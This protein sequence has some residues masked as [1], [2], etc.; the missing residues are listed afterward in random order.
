MMQSEV[1]GVILAG[2]LS[3]RMGCD[4]NLLK[5]SGKTLLENAVTTISSVCEEVFVSVRSSS[6]CL[7]NLHLNDS[8][9]KV[10]VDSTPRIGPMGGII[11]ALTQ[12]QK[13]IMVLACDMPFMTKF[14]LES[15]LSARNGRCQG[16]HMTTF[17]HPDTGFIESL[18]AI[19][20]LEALPILQKCHDE[21]IYKLSKAIPKAQR[22]HIPVCGSSNLCFF[23]TNT[24][25]DITYARNIYVEN[26][27]YA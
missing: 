11:S 27:N 17:L 9:H 5:V 3:S 25:K 21:S 22:C 18:V 26:V 19:Y 24:M 2:G 10:I 4:K 20:E 8:S 12:I 6:N 13:P 15:L 23:N 16:K 1:C 7:D 14:L